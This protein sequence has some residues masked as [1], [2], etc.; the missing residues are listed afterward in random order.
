[1]TLVWIFFGSEIRDGHGAVDVESEEVQG[2]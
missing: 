2:C 1:M